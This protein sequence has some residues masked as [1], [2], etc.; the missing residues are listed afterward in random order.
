MQKLFVAALVLTLGLA[1][2]SGPGASRAQTAPKPSGGGAAAVQAGGVPGP[3][4]P[5]GEANASSGRVTLQM[6]DNMRFGPNLIRVKPGQSV[7]LEVKN[8]GLV[9][10]DFYSPPLGVGAAVTV[11][12]GKSATVG[13][14][15]PSQAGTYPFWCNQ[16][17][18][19]Q[20]GMTGQVVVE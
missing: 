10:H 2:C 8:G 15:A 6:T 13:F 9:A 12:P 1:A 19:A 3:F 5:N 17:G 16:P 4:V 11:D 20:A 18:H 14:T 7:S